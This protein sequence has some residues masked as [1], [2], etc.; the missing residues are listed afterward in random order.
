M[1]A[2]PKNNAVSGIESYVTVC[3]THVEAE[4]A[5]RQLQLGGFEMKRISIVG[6]NSHS[7]ENVIGYYSTGG[8]MKTWGKMGAFWGG[9]WGLL[10]GSAFF[11]I[12]GLGAVMIGGP[13][14]AVM[15]GALEQAEVLGGLGALGA[16][17]YGLGISA[18]SIPA[19]EEALRQGKFLVIAH[20]TGADAAKAKSILAI[21]RAL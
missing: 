7:E 17:L 1:S 20:G 16:G 14:V 12:P 21:T 9:M 19:H 11:M 18:I 13:L 5:V 6:N 4:N 3:S 15:V 2:A 10:S 8:R